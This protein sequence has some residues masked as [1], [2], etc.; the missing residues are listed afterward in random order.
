M[1]FNVVVN[2]GEQTAVGAEPTCSSGIGSFRDGW[3]RDFSRFAIFLFYT[4]VPAGRV[5]FAVLTVFFLKT[6]REQTVGQGTPPR[7]EKIV[8]PVA[9]LS[10]REREA[11]ECLL[12]RAPS[13][14]LSSLWWEPLRPWSSAVTTPACSLHAFVPPLFKAEY[15]FTGGLGFTRGR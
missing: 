2:I 7:K 9:L 1:T 14:R 4:G 6:C 11:R 8:C 13:T 5:I 3:S 12:R 10:P 15:A